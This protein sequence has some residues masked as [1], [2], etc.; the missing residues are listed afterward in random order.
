MR[1]LDQ[2]P[3]M[4]SDFDVSEAPMALSSFPTVP[5]A[6][7]VFGHLSHLHTSPLSFL[8]GL[9]QHGPVAV[10]RFANR[11]VLAVTQPQLVRRL[12]TG[13]QH[14]T[15]KGG[16]VFD[17]M[18]ETLGPD[19]LVTCP[20]A[21]HAQQRPLM[22]PAFSQESLSRYASVMRDAAVKVTGSWRPGQTVQ[23]ETAAHR[24]AALAVSRT[25]V[26]APGAAQA[27]AVLAKA[28]PDISR[29]MYWRSLA[30]GDWFAKLPV[31]VNRR[32]ERQMA[33]ARSAID[34]V[35]VHY[36]SAGIDHEDV[37]SMVIAM[38]EGEPD[39]HQ[40]VYNQTLTMLFGGIETTAAALTW[41][42]RLIDQHQKVVARLQ[43]EL[44]EVLDGELPTHEDISRLTY[45]QQVITE[46]L[47]LFPPAWVGTRMTTSPLEWEEEGI[48]IPAGTELL[49]SPYALHRDAETF[50]RPDHFDP[51]RWAADRAG[52]AQR[53]GF[54]AFSA[55]RRKCIGDTFAMNEVTLALA[56][57]LSRWR[58]DHQ[59]NNPSDQPIPRLILGPPATPVVVQPR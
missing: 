57:I 26:S 19:S 23:M 21:V 54:F 35:A 18:A 50:P 30:P 4:Y 56:I 29:A 53:Q 1:A 40:A 36:R 55:G 15:E 22:Q 25:L 52:A 34:R 28:L 17:V 5:G 58:L 3:P 2:H 6:W 38:C 9:S 7:P 47:R 48:S 46:S 39:P 11:P 42:L 27:A 14:R 59:S 43:T 20:A 13:D 12:L 49:F 8:R 45:T 16:S 32:Y 51:D 31:R 33:I 41:T 37:L 10:V 24:I 44:D